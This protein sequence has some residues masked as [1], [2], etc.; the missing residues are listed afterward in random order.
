MSDDHDSWLDSLRD[1]ARDRPCDE[2]ALQRLMRRLDREA[3]LGRPARPPWQRP[4]S[5]AATITVAVSLGWWL[6]PQG[7]PTRVDPPAPRSA[8][9]PA[10]VP[11]ADPVVDAIQES[12]ADSAP[13]PSEPPSLPASGTEPRADSAAARSERDE[14]SRAATA[15]RAEAEQRKAEAERR[16]HEQAARLQA[17]RRAPTM[18]APDERAA[19]PGDTTPRI[20][21]R[22]PADADRSEALR[23]WTEQL[24]ATPGIRRIDEDKSGT[25]LLAWP[26]AGTRDALIRRLPA[27]AAVPTLPD[28]GRVRIDFAFAAP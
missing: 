24:I 16:Q 14:A 5:V 15:A 2:L 17:E 3:L 19:P 20:V 10:P 27:D 6:L 4:L 9:A 25:L 11:A 8:A 7:R 22:L 26:D 1:E 12:M 23:Q 13:A 18:Q 21:I 28:R